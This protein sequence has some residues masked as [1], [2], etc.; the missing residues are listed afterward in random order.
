VIKDGT[1]KYMVGPTGCSSQELF[2]MKTSQD[3]NKVIAF[4]GSTMERS[5]NSIIE[6]R[7]TGYVNKR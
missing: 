7:I 3:E 1:N 4:Q 6:H 5:K 2:N